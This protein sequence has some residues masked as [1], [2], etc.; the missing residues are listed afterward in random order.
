MMTKNTLLILG[1]I[2][3]VLTALGAAAKMLPVDWNAPMTVL[4]IVGTAVTGFLAQRPRHARIVQD[5]DDAI[6]THLND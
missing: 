4:G 5:H 6:H 3:C 1:L 2:A